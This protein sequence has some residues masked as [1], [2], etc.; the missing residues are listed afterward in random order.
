MIDILLP[1]WPGWADQPTLIERIEGTPKKP[2]VKPELVP[3]PPAPPDVVP[4]E[5]PPLA[6]QIP[7][8][9]PVPPVV[10]DGTKAAF[11][12]VVA[13]QIGWMEY[14]GNVD[15][16][17]SN[18]DSNYQRGPYIDGAYCGQG[19][20]WSFAAAGVPG[21]W[22]GAS[23]QR[24]VPAAYNYWAAIGRI[25][26]ADQVQPGDLLMYDWEGDGIL[27]HIEVAVGLEFRG[28]GLVSVVGY[29]T[30]YPVEGVHW[31]T[32]GLWEID[33]AA[34]PSFTDAP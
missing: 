30:G 4:P 22:K 25:V 15:N 27:D 19:L 24:Y 6:D 23:S 8:G 5:P 10:K 14:Q 28:N 11:L 18:W 33:A 3:L 13:S 9:L 31:T 1:L 26:P 12:A 7:G 17:W 2:W 32:R 34:R 20:S 29:N 21:D 16:P